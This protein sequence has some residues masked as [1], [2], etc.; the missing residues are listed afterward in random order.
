M[1]DLPANIEIEIIELMSGGVFGD[2]IGPGNTARRINAEHGL[3][4]TPDE[5]WS[6]WK[7]YLP[8]D[9]D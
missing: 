2:G 5:V 1:I 4:L 9:E 3:N 7:S 8:A 6:L